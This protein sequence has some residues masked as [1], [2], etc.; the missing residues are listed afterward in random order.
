M[1]KSLNTILAVLAFAVLSTAC[2][3]Q[4]DIGITTKVKSLL[5]SDRAISNAA[6]IQVTTEKKVVTLAGPVDSPATKAHAVTLAK[7]VEGVKK[8]VDNLTVAPT[9]VAAAQPAAAEAVPDTT[10]APT[11][12]AS[13][14]AVKPM[15]TTTK[16]AVKPATDTATKP[17]AKPTTDKATKQA[18]KPATTQAAIPTTDMATPETAK[19]ATDMATPETAKPATDTAATPQA[20]KPT[21]TAITQAVKDK[22]LLRPEAST[23]SIGVDTHE[24]VVTLSGTVKSP[25]V[26][27]Q[28]IRTARGIEGVQRVEDKLSVSSS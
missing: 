24:G 22:L 6:Q 28:V 26:K 25:E 15:D 1:R 17:A 3:Q 2:T 11:D 4:A 5:D 14:Q 23:E 16:P 10:T 7:G 19:P 9:S 8:V 21:D 27:A 12:T 20:V 13:T 18:V